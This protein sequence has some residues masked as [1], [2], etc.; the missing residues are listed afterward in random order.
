MIY[1]TRSQQRW[2]SFSINRFRRM[3]FFSYKAF[4]LITSLTNHH[5]D[6]FP[7][8]GVF[9]QSFKE[10]FDYS[11]VIT[12]LYLYKLKARMNSLSR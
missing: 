5:F 9:T 12:R 6:P 1:R 2:F 10:I 4:S 3:I 8:I 7:E 11:S